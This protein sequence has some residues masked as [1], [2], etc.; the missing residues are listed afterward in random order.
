[1]SH[2]AEATIE[3]FNC[4]LDE[5]RTA[6]S[7]VIPQWADHIAC[8]EDGHLSL[9]GWNATGVESG[10]QQDFDDGFYLV[11]PGN[12]RVSRGR[13]TTVV[14]QQMKRK[15]MIQGV[16]EAEAE[17]RATRQAIKYGLTGDFGVRKDENGNWQIRIDYF[18]LDETP[19]KGVKG[20]NR[21]TGLQ[22]GLERAKKQGLVYSPDMFKPENAAKEA[23]WSSTVLGP[24]Q[25]RIKTAVH[26][27]RGMKKLAQ[28]GAEFGITI[29]QPFQDVMPDSAVDKAKIR[30][31]LQKARANKEKLKAIVARLKKKV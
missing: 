13:P 15:L 30:F 31:D 4:T 5:L 24:F 18:G 16:P 2:Y 26:K 10:L 17:K 23:E 14:D 1:M 7:E 22:E 20:V 25:N 19:T 28:E 12:R 29:T 27:R 21:R 11:V 8:D 3:N 6:I 9:S